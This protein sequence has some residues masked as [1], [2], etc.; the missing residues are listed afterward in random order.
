MVKE[1]CCC[2]GQS[3][4]QKFHTAALDFWVAAGKQ[5]FRKTWSWLKIPGL[6]LQFSGLLTMQQKQ[7]SKETCSA[8]LMQDKRVKQHFSYVATKCSFTW[9]INWLCWICEFIRVMSFLLLKLVLQLWFQ[10]CIPC[11][12]TSVHA[13]PEFTHIYT[14]KYV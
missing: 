1:L 10:R 9:S 7:K 8:V 6:V 4:I 12:L 14:C 5:C 13:I 2:C 3:C 11:K